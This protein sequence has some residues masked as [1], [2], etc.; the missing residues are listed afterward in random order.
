MGPLASRWYHCPDLFGRQVVLVGQVVPQRRHL[1]AGHA[2]QRAARSTEMDVSVVVQRRLVHVTST[3]D[4]TAV[5]RICRKAMVGQSEGHRCGY[6]LQTP[7]AA[8]QGG[9][10]LMSM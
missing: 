10:R 6:E 1:A 9:N 2:T 8:E 4:V 7:T 5:W 3:T